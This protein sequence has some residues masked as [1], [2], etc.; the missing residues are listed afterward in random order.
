MAHYDPH[1]LEQYAAILYRKAFRIVVSFTILGALVGGLAGL[2]FGGELGKLIPVEH[3][4]WL[5]P[6]IVL[7]IGIAF[8]YIWGVARAFTYKLNAQLALCQKEIEANTRRGT[9]SHP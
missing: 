2:I 9:A 6:L 4:A 5:P 3:A 1:I 7:V 8:G